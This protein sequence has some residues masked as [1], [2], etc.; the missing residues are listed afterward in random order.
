MFSSLDWIDGRI[1]N[2]IYI[3]AYINIIYTCIYV[4]MCIIKSWY[5]K[6]FDTYVQFD[7]FTN[8]EGGDNFWMC[9]KII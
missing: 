1:Y 9:S 7:W 8:K 2:Y 5:W 4:A 3:Y 6:L